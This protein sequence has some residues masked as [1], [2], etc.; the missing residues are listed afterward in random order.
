MKTAKVLASKGKASMRAV[1]R[2]IDGGVDVDLD[3][4]CRIE[5]DAFALCLSS[6]DGQEGMTAFLEKRKAN[7]KGDL[8][9]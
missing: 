5:A 8:D 2:C 4:G 7:F 3:S 6:P 9:E 1:K